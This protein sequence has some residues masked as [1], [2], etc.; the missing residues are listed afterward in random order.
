MAGATGGYGR[1]PGKEWRHDAAGSQ[2]APGR[3]GVGVSGAVPP[4]GLSRTEQVCVA[5]VSGTV[6]FCHLTGIAEACWV[7]A[8]DF[9]F[10]F[11]YQKGVGV[12]W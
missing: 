1:P 11:H 5:W 4:L 6:F 9:F 12:R 7:G 10:F 3:P 2:E 8:R